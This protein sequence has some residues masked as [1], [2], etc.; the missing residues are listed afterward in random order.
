M[1]VLNEQEENSAIFNYYQMGTR[2]VTSDV[3]LQIL[4]E[5]L[6]SPL[7]EELRTKQ[8]LGYIVGSK[9]STGYGTHGL[10]VYVQSPGTPAN[11]LDDRPEKG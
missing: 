4:A 11:E 9:T 1:K 7:F 2:S 3:Q 6:A 5:V 10:S 8:Q